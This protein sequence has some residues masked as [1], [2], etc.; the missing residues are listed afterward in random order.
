MRRT[1]LRTF[2]FTA[3]LGLGCM[4]VTVT[5]QAEELKHPIELGKECKV[6]FQEYYDR[7]RSDDG[8]D[9]GSDG[10]RNFHF[11]NAF[12]YAYGATGKYACGYDV[13]PRPALERCNFMSSHSPGGEASFPPGTTGKELGGCKVYAKSPVNGKLAIVWKEEPKQVVKTEAK[14]ADA[15]QPADELKQKHWAGYKTKITWRGWDLTIRYSESG[16]NYFA[17]IETPSAI[18]AR[19]EGAVD[20][21]GNLERVDC[22]PDFGNWARRDLAGNVSRIELLNPGG[23]TDGGAV[24]VDKKLAQRIKFEADRQ[25]IKVEADRQRIKVEAD[26][27]R[28]KVEA[29]RQRIAAE[30]ARKLAEAK[31][32]AE[33]PAD[34]LKDGK[35]SDSQKN[36]ANPISASNRGLVVEL[37]ASEAA[38]APVEKSVKL[39]SASYA[40]VIGNDDYQHWPKL[41]NA[42]KDARLVG[43]ELEA[44]GFEVTYRTNLTGDELE[45]ALE[46]FYIEKGADI[47]AR[48]LLWFAGH[49]D[50]VDG[51]GYLVPIDAPSSGKKTHF[52]RKALS[53]R[54]FGEYVREANAKHALGIF[55]ACFAGTIFEIQRSRPPP[56]ITQA[57]TMEVRQFF[58]SGDEGEEVR[59]DGTFRKLFIRALRGEERADANNDG[60]LTGSELGFFLHD[61]IVN[62]KLGQTPRYGKL[63]DPDF[64]RGDFVFAI[65]APIKAAPVRSSAPTENNAEIVFWQSIQNSTNPKHFE[66]YLHQFP[67]GVFA[68]LAKVNLDILKPKQMTRPKPAPKLERVKS[69]PKQ[70]ARL[71]PSAG[72]VPANETKVIDGVWSG[73]LGNC[74]AI[75]RGMEETSFSARLDTNDARSRLQMDIQTVF[76]PATSQFYE[77]VSK[78]FGIAPPGIAEWYFEDFLNWSVNPPEILWKQTSKTSGPNIVRATA[79][80]SEGPNPIVLKVSGARE[81]EIKLSYK[82]PSKIGS[83]GITP[84]PTASLNPSYQPTTSTEL[85]SKIT[86]YIQPTSG[87]VWNGKLLFS[88]AT[89]KTVDGNFSVDDHVFDCGPMNQKFSLKYTK[90]SLIFKY[91]EKEYLVRKKVD[92]NNRKEFKIKFYHENQY[93]NHSLN[94]ILADWLVM[95]TF[96]ATPKFKTGKCEGSIA[97]ISLNHATYQ[98]VVNKYGSEVSS[99]NLSEDCKQYAGWKDVN[100]AG[101]A[102]VFGMMGAAA[103]K[104]EE[105]RNTEER[106]PIV[107][108]CEVYKRYKN[109]SQLR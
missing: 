30:L 88:E 82:G 69:Q 73:V 81:C 90:D 8:P 49:G 75:P 79:D 34:E 11:Y 3:I 60:Y 105:K 43:K 68:T 4:G 42:I 84:R 48:L 59:D 57:T 86:N 93:L 70:V 89:V 77:T 62:L 80:L 76:A 83:A 108:A 71:N 40:L 56:A 102:M 13:S 18:K 45:E 17:V 36:V 100:V 38:N 55:D 35:Y 51:N 10:P 78:S 61:R 24:F 104:A 72:T 14:M 91:D 32:E 103:A 20:E 95:G 67:Y 25:R 87:T 85:Q 46:E 12:A 2:L 98:A 6:L 28:I 7:I 9:D 31:A 47:G 21:S 97:G 64:D 50:T 74:G 109:I 92:I 19:C 65:N 66:A 39:Y 52:K 94:L 1:V 26:R 99:G 29:D 107:R 33:K 15:Q 37:R 54:R 16:E 23:G 106:L 101:S 5:G 27:Q 63:R 53:L 22:T 44:H 96:I 41:S 58:T